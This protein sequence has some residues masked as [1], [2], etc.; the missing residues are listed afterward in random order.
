MRAVYDGSFEGFLSLVY[1][2]Y[3]K[4]LSVD[5][6]TT[7]MPNSLFAEDIIEIQ[8]DL[9]HANKVL[10]ALKTKLSKKQ[11]EV[12]LNTFMCDSKA[13][14]MDLLGYIRI[15]FSNPKELNNINQKCIFS[16]HNYQKE[17]FRLVHKMSGFVRFEE[18]EDG[19]LYAKIDV[20]FNIVYFLGRHFMKRFNNQRFIIHDLSR[21]LAFIY[22]QDFVGVREVV[23]FE[24]PKLGVDEIKFQKLWQT[25]FDSVSIESRHNPKLQRNF[26]PLIYRTYMSEFNS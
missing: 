22:S 1:A 13:F 11:F 12:I 7:Q 26:V 10:N 4:K 6:I 19:T 16:M 23:A 5:S 18:L 24:Q 17:L 25:F 2:L 9:I 21:K 8:T 15:A 20:K 3:Y 14:E